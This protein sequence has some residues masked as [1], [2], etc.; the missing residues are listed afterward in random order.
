MH[1]I[2]IDLLLDHLRGRMA[3]VQSHQKIRT[4][5]LPHS[6]CLQFFAYLLLEFG[7][8]VVD[9]AHDSIVKSPFHGS[10]VA[11]VVQPLLVDEVLLIALLFSILLCQLTGIEFLVGLGT[12]CQLQIVVLAHV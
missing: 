9:P 3:L 4:H 10:T 7:N 6:R 8:E 2:L 12:R 1:H 5:D 11:N